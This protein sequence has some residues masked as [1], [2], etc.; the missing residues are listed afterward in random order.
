MLLKT[1]EKL[2]QRFAS[3]LRSTVLFISLTL[4]IGWA[5]QYKLV[6]QRL[7]IDQTS[8]T[9]DHFEQPINKDAE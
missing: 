9:R 3:I 8:V 5:L 6:N 7:N 1:E 2:V 4:V